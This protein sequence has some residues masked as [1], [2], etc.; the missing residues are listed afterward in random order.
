MTDAYEEILQSLEE[1]AALGVVTL[2][3][4]PEKEGGVVDN[5]VGAVAF[6]GENGAMIAEASWTDRKPIITVTGINPEN[7]ETLRLSVLD[8]EDAVL[9]SVDAEQTSDRV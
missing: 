9:I 2:E 1:R 4:D 8:F 6:R 5:I 7:G 3:E